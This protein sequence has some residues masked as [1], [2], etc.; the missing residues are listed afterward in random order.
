MENT[1]ALV[2]ALV[3]LYFVGLGFILLTEWALKKIVHRPAGLGIKRAAWLAPIASVIVVVAL[4]AWMRVMN[5]CDITMGLTVDA[6]LA[7]LPKGSAIVIVPPEALQYKG[8]DVSLRLAKKNLA[9]LINDAKPKAPKGT[10]IKGIPE[11]RMSP[12]MK[13]EL[14][15]EDFIVE[16]NGLQ[17]QSVTLKEDTVWT[18]RVHSERLGCRTLKFRLNTLITGREAP[19]TIEVAEVQIAVKLNPFEW[20]LRHWEWIATALVFPIVAWNWKRW[21]GGE[22]N[23]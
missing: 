11:V 2:G 18:W 1:L 16:G 6:L 20:T 14:I 17:E 7:K 21:F 9:Q 5:P 13:A 19:R 8:F 3:I 10:I 15:G 23:T 4:T 22:V 12:Y